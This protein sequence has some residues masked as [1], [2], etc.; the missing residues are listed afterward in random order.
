MPLLAAERGEIDDLVVVDAPLDDGVD[1]DRIEPGLLRGGDPVEHVRQ[2]VA[3]G[4]LG[5]P[6]PIQRVEADVHPP[7]P[8]LAQRAGHEPHRGAVRRHRQIDG[9]VGAAQGGQLGD[10]Y[11]QVGPHGRFATRE[12]DALDAVA[13][14][15]HPRQPLDLLERHH[16]GTRQPM[17]PLLGHAVRAAEVA[18]IGDRDPQIPDD[19]GR[20]DRPDPRLRV[21]ALPRTQPTD[22]GARRRRR[23]PRRHPIRRAGRRSHRRW[24][25]PPTGDCPAPRPGA[26][27][28]ARRPRR[29][30]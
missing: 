29:R 20:T 25:W 28:T 1:L 24:R 7:Q 10:Q 13:L 4:H 9:P 19:R 15:E 6:L 21:S 18:A 22:R 27:G 26:R 12:P 8:G 14:D 16:V 23:H 2:L 30:R 3:A 17:H 11:R 5:E